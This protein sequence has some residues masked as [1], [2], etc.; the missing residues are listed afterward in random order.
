MLVLSRKLNEDIT[1]GE[2][3]RVK[4]VRIE[5]DTVKLGIEAPQDVIIMRP[6]VLAK[7]KNNGNGENG[8][9]C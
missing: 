9:V 8:E 1:I 7:K 2:N 3:I 5:R 6:E 4:I